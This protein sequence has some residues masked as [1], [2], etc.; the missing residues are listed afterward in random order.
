MTRIL[1]SLRQWCPQCQAATTSIEC[2]KCGA[3]SCKECGH[4]GAV[5]TC[6]GDDD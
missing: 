2:E 3:E 6:G 5:K 1:A 4:H